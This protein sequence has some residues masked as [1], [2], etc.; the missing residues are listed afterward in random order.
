[1]G[2]FDFVKSGVREISIARPDSMKQML[3]YKHPDQNIP[4]GSQ[5]TVDM[6]EAAVFYKDGQYV[7]VLPPGRHT[8]H[9]QNIPFL[10]QWVTQLTGGNVFIAEIFFLLTRPKFNIPFGASVD[11]VVD[12]MTGES[13]D[14]GVNGDFA[15]QIINPRAFI[16]GFHGLSQVN[17]PDNEKWIKNLLITTATSVIG[18]VLEEVSILKRAAVS[19]RL[20]RTIMSRAPDFAQYGL[21]LVQIARAEI[22]IPDPEDRARLQ[23]AQAEVAAKQRGVKMADLDAQANQFKLDQ[24]NRQRQVENDQRFNQ[25][26]RYVQ[27]LAGNWQNYNAGLALQGAGQGM[28]AHGVG[29]GIA[30][31]GAEVAVGASVGGA[32]A[33]AFQNQPQFAVGQPQQPPQQAPQP[34]QPVAAPGAGGAPGMLTCSKCNAR[35]PQGKFCAECGSPLAPPKK[36]CTNCAQELVP[37]TVKFCANCGTSATAPQPAGPG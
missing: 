22:T 7:G 21:K 16:E 27:N 23:A 24:Q 10:N 37:P 25:D 8:M 17:D 36:F 32:M 2:V 13:V 18:E 33:S 28:A 14:A 5:V 29:G 3:C 26:A 15:V 34:Q 20:V 9:T 30:G 4:W 6:D 19:E 1:M 11:G 31:L 35:Q 12:T